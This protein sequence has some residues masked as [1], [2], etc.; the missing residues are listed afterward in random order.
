[1]K[2]ILV[3]ITG[4]LPIPSIKGGAVETLIDAYLNADEKQGKYRFTVYSTY[5]PEIETYNF[6]YQYS[7]FRFIH[8][9]KLSFKISRYLRA[10]LNKVL[11]INVRRAFINEVLKDLHRQ[12]EKDFDYV[13]VENDPMIINALS[14]VYPQ[15]IILHLHND[16]LNSTTR[17]ALTTYNNCRSI[18]AVSNYIKE[19]IETINNQPSSKAHVLMNGINQEL[20]RKQNTP[21]NRQRI[22]KKYHIGQDD[23]VFI[24]SGRICADKGVYELLQAFSKL[25][26]KNRHT[27]LLIVG[28]SF[29]SSTKK[30]KYIKKLQT[31][32]QKVQ[33]QIIFTGYVPYKDMGSIYSA[34]DIQIIPSIFDDPCPLA[35]IEGMTMGL[36]QIATISGGIPE[37]LSQEN[38]I[39]IHRENII[40]ELYNAMNKL[41]ADNALRKKM[42]DASAKRS[43]EFTEEKYVHNFYKLLEREDSNEK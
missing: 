4:N 28:G 15:K 27:K 9:N 21:D 12:N 23:I 22:R 39:F 8:T 37:E 42:A 5:A 6:A 13:I 29:F 34:A 1:M 25:Q 35:A 32:S 33:E 31:L 43:K 19:R 7:N 11:K 18:Y 40:E 2:K 14:K 20:F 17:Y 41:V 36:P 10:F 3:I 26:L 24:F 16:N 30:T 38:A